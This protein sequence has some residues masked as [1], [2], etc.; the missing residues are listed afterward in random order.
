MSCNRCSQNYKGDWNSLPTEI[1][2][3]IFSELSN[4]DRI[5]ASEVCK[6]WNRSFNSSQLWQKIKVRFK[7]S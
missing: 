2:F 4:E 1:Y 3:K 6:S 5:N 7:K